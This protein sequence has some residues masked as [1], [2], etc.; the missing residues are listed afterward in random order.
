[1]QR[2]YFGNNLVEAETLYQDQREM[3]INK[4]ARLW[5]VF[6]PN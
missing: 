6:N 3:G 1:M 4:W 2:I 5:K